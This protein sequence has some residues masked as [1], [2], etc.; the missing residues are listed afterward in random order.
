MDKALKRIKW[1]GRCAATMPKIMIIKV[2]LIGRAMI[3]IITFTVFRR[4]NNW[5]DIPSLALYGGYHLSYHRYDIV[6]DI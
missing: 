6:Y 2:V 5:N 3:K 4:T 1:P